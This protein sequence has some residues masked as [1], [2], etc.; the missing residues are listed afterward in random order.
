MKSWNTIE[1]IKSNSD[2]CH[3]RAGDLCLH[4]LREAES[5]EKEFCPIRDG[6]GNKSILKYILKWLL[7]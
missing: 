1:I 5:C 2:E 6:A 4:H 3:R 7:K